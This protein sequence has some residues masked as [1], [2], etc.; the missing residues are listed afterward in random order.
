MRRLIDK[1]SLIIIS[2]FLCTAVLLL[3]TGLPG[4]HAADKNPVK[5]GCL[6]PL[7]TPGDSAA[8]KRIGWGAELAAKYINEEM[9]GV[10]CGRHVEVVMGDDAGTPSEGIAGFRRLVEKD[11]VSAV[12]GQYHSSVCLALV[13][14]ATDLEVPL[15]STGAA[16]AKITATESP[17]IFSIISLTDQYGMFWVDFAK[18]MGWNKMGIM[19]EDTDYGTDLVTAAKKYAKDAGIEVKSIV[20]PRTSSDLT[21]MLLEMKAWEP[22]VVID[23]AVPPTAY[24]L[25]KQAGD[26]GLFPKT[27]MI[28]SYNWCALPEYWNA[29]GDNG[30]YILFADHFR[31]GM[32]ATFLGEWLISKYRQLHD[33]DPTYYAINAFGEVMVIAQAINMA[34]SE[35]PKAIAKALVKWPFLDWSGIVDFKEE[36]GPSWHL[37]SAPLLMFQMTQVRQEF[38]DTKLVWPPK[39]GGDGKI[40]TP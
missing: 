20:Y 4:T 3:G 14:V 8:G 23:A 35:N 33:E 15:I 26:V 22:Q 29:V 27:P 5:I 1:K 18:H 34:Q 17:Y 25:V 12:V 6:T 2:I 10:L 38:K 28:A 13:K 36:K 7:S 32:A 40:D 19:S 37:V 31:K 16:S 39:F 9:G 21:P 30:R 11:G 24:L